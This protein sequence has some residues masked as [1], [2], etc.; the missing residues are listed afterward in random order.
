M[1][2]KSLPMIISE[3]EQVNGS[4]AAAC[5]PG[6]AAEAQRRPDEDGEADDGGAQA[7][8]DDVEVG[9]DEGE[10]PAVRS[11]LKA[12]GVGGHVGGRK[13]YKNFKLALHGFVESGVWRDGV[14]LVCTGSDF[15]DQELELFRQVGVPHSIVSVGLVDEAALFCLYKH[16]HCLLYTSR[17]EGFGLPLIEAMSVGC[18]VIGAEVSCIPEI[19]GKA[20]IL[21]NADSPNQVAR[22]ILDLGSTS[23]RDRVI[24]DG[25]IRASHFS[26]N[27]SASKHMEI[28]ASMASGN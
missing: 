23:L 14:K 12:G 20:G 15:N 2:L 6:G 27:I 11:A 26:W 3:E 13:N 1:R 9:V 5:R 25:L 16:A 21:V 8:P 10:V 28:Y 18:P 4:E 24:A 7:A 22:A 19:V 17:Y